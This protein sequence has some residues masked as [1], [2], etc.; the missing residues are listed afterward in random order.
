MV[1]IVAVIFMI[2]LVILAVL[3]IFGIRSEL[4]RVRVYDQPGGTQ[5]NGIGLNL[6]KIPTSNRIRNASFDST[7]EYQVLTVADAVGDHIFFDPE[8]TAEGLYDVPGNKVKI[9]SLD[10]DGVMSVRF[11]SETEGF[12]EAGFGMVTKIDDTEGFWINDPV[13]K[14]ACVSSTVDVLTESG[15]IISD[16]TSEQLIREFNDT[17]DIFADIF[18]SEAGVF[19]LSTEGKVFWSVDG[20]TFALMSDCPEEEVYATAIAAV[21]TTPVF[22]T[23]DNSLYIV[24]SGKAVKVDTPFEGNILMIGSNGTFMT[25]ADDL[26]NIYTSYNGLV[27]SKVSSLSEG[28]LP[29]S[30]EVTSDCSYI[31]DN[32]GKI[33]IIGSEG[34]EVIDI[35]SSEPEAMTVSDDGRIVVVTSDLKACLISSSTGEIMDLTT[36]SGAVE[37]V[38]NG[39]DGRF[40]TENANNLYFA[41]VLSALRVSDEI[42]AD[43]V[44]TGDICMISF[45]EEG[46]DD[47][48]LYGEETAL[49]TSS[50]DGTYGV[51]EGDGD[52]AH[53]LTQTLEMNCSDN[54]S[55][56]SFYRISLRLKSG[57]SS[58]KNAMVWL[59]GDTFGNVG[60]TVEGITDKFET[61]SYVFAVTENMISEEDVIR[62]NISFEGE[63]ELSVD[64]IYVGEDRYDKDYVPD[65][66]SDPVIAACPAAIRYDYLGFG[67]S[68]FSEER[69]YSTDEESLETALRLSRDCGSSPWIVIGSCAG[70][71][72]IDTL[73]DYLC[74]SVSSEY[75]KKR[76]DNGTALPWNRQ[77]DTVYIEIRDTEG[78]FMSDAQRGAYVSYIIDAFNRSQY[79]IDIKDNIV[80]LDG[81]EYEGGT[82]LSSADYHASG[83]NFRV[84]TG[85]RGTMLEQI[86]NFYS[87]SN[88][89]T[90]RMAS[91]S[92]DGGE[93][94]SSLSIELPE[95]RTL[96]AGEMTSILINKNAAS[97]IRM[98][99]VD[100]PVSDRPVD[101]ESDSVFTM[102]GKIPVLKVMPALSMLR[103]SEGIY[104]EVL[105]PLDMSSGVSASSFTSACSILVTEDSGGR[106]VIV[107]NCSGSVQQFITEGLDLSATEATVQRYSASGTLLSERNVRG[108][109]RYTLQSGESLIIKI[110]GQ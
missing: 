8:T 38:F 86:E 109:G 37:R 64:D 78:I 46:V 45:L 92:A 100:L 23:E 18:G 24:S 93:F 74:G 3:G 67:S 33:T 62:F 103:Y 105:D 57:D 28:T 39:T 41:T 48:D 49:S 13:V 58:V 11:Q 6:E 97:Y 63:G 2:A 26:G 53:T 75:G 101:T 85:Y 47:W 98:I 9:L 68:G 82:V 17:E 65:S 99:M 7:S 52:G 10:S 12:D 83:L 43:A 72:D 5:S 56:D 107:S 71:E 1:V 40:I 19:A 76:I 91:H 42:P 84:M 21:G 59:N 34:E 25:L 88:Y 90:P 89:D 81:M 79:Y 20:R 50:D 32:S 96:T 54:F 16:I 106:Y 44:M 77:F 14:T 15:K 55:D 94:I 110:S 35:S 22:T 70:K 36:A 31:L 87:D 73:M 27:F 102:A 66:F 69:F 95:D 60:F 61:Y 80:L 4:P 108:N 104:Y 29:V 51:L 30:V